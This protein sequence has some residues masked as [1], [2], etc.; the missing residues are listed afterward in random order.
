[1]TTPASQSLD[2]AT[3]PWPML[4]AAVRRHGISVYISNL[5][6]DFDRR[7]AAGG[8]TCNAS[9]R[10]CRFDSYG[11]RLYVTALEVAWFRHRLQQQT[12]GG[13]GATRAGGGSDPDDSPAHPH[14]LSLPV[15]HQPDP[16]RADA[17]PF[18]K[19]NTC[20]VHTIRPMGCRIYFCQEGTDQWQQSLYE[21]FHTRL[22]A[23]HERLDL[24]YLYIEWRQGLAES[25]P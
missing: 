24:P 5:Y 16:R 10:C 15:L 22:R 9:G 3:H 7:I 23:L 25:K 18:Q 19:N 20:T 8:A 21:A 2:A 14:P 12:T 6:E 13:K 11:H 4:A 1:M 17:C